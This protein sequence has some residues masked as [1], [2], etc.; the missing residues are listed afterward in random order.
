MSRLRNDVATQ[1]LCFFKIFYFFFCSA[2]KVVLKLFWEYFKSVKQCFEDISRKFGVGSF[3]WRFKEL[4]TGASRVLQACF[5]GFHKKVLW[6][7]SLS[8]RAGSQLPMT[9]VD[10]YFHHSFLLPLPLLDF[11][12]FEA[13]Q[14]VSKCT[15]LH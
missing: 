5:K 2:F 6:L 3:I 15:V 1:S 10:R 13:L 9:L 12:G 14:A 11:E 4:L 8:R 7:L